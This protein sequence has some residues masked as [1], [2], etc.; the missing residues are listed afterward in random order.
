MAAAQLVVALRALASF[1]HLQR[2]SVVGNGLTTL[3]PL[4]SLRALS[5][6]NASGNRLSGGVLHELA[7][8]SL[9]ELNLSDNCIARIDPPLPAGAPLAA[10]L[11]TLLLQGNALRSL[12]GLESMRRLAHLD[13]AGNALEDL[14]P[15]A[16]LAA[17]A[18]LDVSR[19]PDLRSL[20]GLCGAGGG[21]RV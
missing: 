21:A 1:K 18:L 12:A 3:A 8:L 20:R 5:R 14:A 2:V 13:A 16:G 11:A 4:A 7:S 10:S 19:N 6:L 17:L 15:I 9:R